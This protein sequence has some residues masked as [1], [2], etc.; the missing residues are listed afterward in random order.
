MLALLIVSA[1]ALLMIGFPVWTVFLAFSLGWVAVSPA[2]L[3]PEIL[4]SRLFS[5]LNIYALLAVPGFIFAAE[6]MVRGGM[7]KRLVEWVASL[8]GRIP[9]GM[10]VATVAASEVFGAM[11]GSSTAT[12]AGVGRVLYPA[13]R[14]GG[15]SEHFSLGLIT[16]MGALAVILPPSIIMI[17]YGA[18]AGV[19]VSSL[20]L[21]GVI[22]GI[23]IGILVALYSVFWALRHK[24]ASE[25]DSFDWRRVLNTSRNAIWTLGAPVIIFGGIYSGFF[26][27]TEASIVLVMYSI[28]VAMLVYRE[29]DLSELW[30]VAISSALLTAKI[31]VI[32]ASASVF[33]LVL[34][35]EK[36]PD[37]LVS[38]MMSLEMNS[39]LILLMLNVI[40]LIVG[41]FLDPNSAI[42]VLL[43]LL[44][45]IASA[46]EVDLIHFGIIMTVNLAIG[47]FTPPF[48]LNIYVS[49]SIFGTPATRVAIGVL[50]FVGLYIIALIVIT[51]VPWLSLWLPS[52]VN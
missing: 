16:S 49:T 27:P 29:L 17:L 41:M 47:M 25:Q 43:P 12:V 7:A 46:I 24:I 44:L 31:F 32:V 23:M 21:G 52:L 40:L 18:I 22:P 35:I 33:A 36:V 14:S 9:G 42:V 19:S 34:V 4:A 15:Y 28:F 10:P 30:D 38:A 11:S 51:F 2:A 48:G 39:L 8:F 1:I 6:I 50:P 37:Q 5:G 20:F 13:L 45:P 3:P 26:T